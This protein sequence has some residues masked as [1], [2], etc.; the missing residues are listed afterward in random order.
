M[1]IPTGQ[2]DEGANVEGRDT[3]VPHGDTADS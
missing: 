1:R 3:T 2:G